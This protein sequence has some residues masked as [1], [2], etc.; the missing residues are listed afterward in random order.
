M[1]RTRMRKT[2]DVMRGL[3][4]GLRECNEHDEHPPSAHRWRVSFFRVSVCRRSRSNLT[5]SVNAST[6]G[7]AVSSSC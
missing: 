3:T 1:G 7:D 6:A 4:P 2:I 5:C